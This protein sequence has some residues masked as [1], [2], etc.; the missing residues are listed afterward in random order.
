MNK[1]LILV[2]AVIM[3]ISTAGCT[4]FGGNRNGPAH[5]SF[6]MAWQSNSTYSIPISSFK[7]NNTSL[8]NLI[9]AKVHVKL[10]VD[11]STVN[12]GKNY[13]RW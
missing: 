2:I 12:R 11:N 10:I 7:L 13:E 6:D 4:S 5:F 9:Y 1:I 8:S 3:V